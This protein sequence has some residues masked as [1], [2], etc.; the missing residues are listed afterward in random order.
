MIPMMAGVLV[1]ST[2]AGQLITRRGHIKPYIV[3][4]SISLVIGFVILSFMD[5]RTPLWI[6]WA[7]MLLVG[8]GVGMTMQNFVLAVQN[9][10]ALRDLGASSG[11]VT[12]FR[13]LGGTA[14]VAVLG[15]V[16]SAQVTA[17]LAEKFAQAGIPFSGGGSGGTSLDLNSLPAPVR[18]IVQSAYGDA[19]G[20][21]FLVSAGIGL[22]A[23][24][25]AVL[26]PP[27]VLRTSIDLP[28]KDPVGIDGLP[29]SEQ[30]IDA[31]R[32]TVSATPAAPTRRPARKQNARKR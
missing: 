2:V 16:L 11:A 31:V 25:A 26:L 18:E 5:H 22:L 20:H 8:A 3:G 27:V 24:L 17:N 23:I 10:V 28:D 7:G 32:E 9:S 6:L 21:I 4:G 15:A 1:A 19:T 30:S 14:G 13:S 12:F 29:E